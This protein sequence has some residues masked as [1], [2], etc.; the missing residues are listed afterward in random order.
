ML[1][2]NMKCVESNG[3]IVSGILNTQT[4]AKNGNQY[5]YMNDWKKFNET[6]P[7]KEQFYSHANVEGITDAD[8]T[9]KER[10]FRDFFVGS[11]TSL[12]ADIFWNECLQIYDPNLA[13]FLSAPGLVWQ[14]SLK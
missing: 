9:H 1:I 12:L 4:V 6:L 7:G 3:K 13:H 14:V 11:D 8:Y 5:E 2:R 10:V